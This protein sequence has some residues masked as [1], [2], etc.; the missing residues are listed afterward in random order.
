M[1]SLSISSGLMQISGAIIQLVGKKIMIC[2]LFVSLEEKCYDKNFTM[3]SLMLHF[4][5]ITLS[6]S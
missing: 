6:T 5:I 1:E 3:Q 4:H 2:M